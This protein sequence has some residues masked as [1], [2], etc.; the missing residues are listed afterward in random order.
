MG[1]KNH[2]D[3]MDIEVKGKMKEKGL[4]FVIREKRDQTE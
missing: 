3:V 1:V 4:I 2:I